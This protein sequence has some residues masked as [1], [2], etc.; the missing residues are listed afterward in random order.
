MHTLR[1]LFYFTISVLFGL[2][3]TLVQ[4]IPIRLYG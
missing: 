3:H 2:S 1:F 4:I